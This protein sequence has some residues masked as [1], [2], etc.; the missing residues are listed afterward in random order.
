M[1]QLHKGFDHY[2]GQAPRVCLVTRRSLSREAFQAA[3]Y[4]AEDVLSVSS[5]VDLI[6]IQPGRS[7]EFRSRL[8]KSL[9]F[10]G[11]SLGL[12]Y[13]NPGLRKVRLNQ[14]YDIFIAVCQ[15]LWDL[16]YFNAIDG[17]KER[18]KIS[19]CWLGELWAADIPR[20]SHFLGTL[21]RFDHVVLS[22]QGSVEPLSK[23]L[24]RECHLVPPGIDT[25][26][27]SPFPRLPDRLIDA[28]SIGRRWEGVHRALL[29]AASEQKLFYLYDSYRDMAVMPVFDHAQHRA[30]FANLAKRSK[31]FLVSPGKMNLP[32]ETMGQVEVGHRY[33]EG[34]AAGAVMIGQAAD[35]K[36]FWELFPWPDA[37]VEISPDGSDVLELIS[38]L[39]STPERVRT[40]SRRNAIE[41]LL[42]HDWI[43]RWIQIFRIAGIEPSPGM[44]ARVE[45][46]KELAKAPL[47]T[48]NSRPGS[49]ASRRDGLGPD[50]EHASP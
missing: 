5:N 42:R 12:A 38:C 30:L 28:Y 48:P 23:F 10:H 29:G 25:L 20:C 6:E 36:L 14:D 37:V 43:H 31:Y 44:T 47:C 11:I 49:S 34:A 24:D 45:H 22:S 19:V 1:S 27:F 35:C 46:L 41:C 15:N 32:G 3:L 18:C 21:R 17:W 39:D 4:E 50:A 33:F 9:L 16:L 40:I 7:F 13:V 2:S 26:R 8:Q